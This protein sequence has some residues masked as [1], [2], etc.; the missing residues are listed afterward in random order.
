[1]PKLLLAPSG[2]LTPAQGTSPAADLLCAQ[3][4]PCLCSLTLKPPPVYTLFRK[5]VLLRAHQSGDIHQVCFTWKAPRADGLCPPH[6]CWIRVLRPLSCSTE[7]P[8]AK[9]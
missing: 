7:G 9:A 6:P 5:V 1:M 8:R 2:V 3:Q 4:D